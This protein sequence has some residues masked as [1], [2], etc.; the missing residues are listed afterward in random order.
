MITGAQRVHPW[1]H[2]SKRAS[3]I[4]LIAK[5]VHP[6]PHFGLFLR[7][8]LIAKIKQRPSWPHFSKVR[9]KKMGARPIP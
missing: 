3:A 8:S 6:W 5:S 4:F 1:P 7:S 2:F 9:E